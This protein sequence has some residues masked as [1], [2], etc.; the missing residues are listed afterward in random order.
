M[1]Q[2]ATKDHELWMQ[3][4]IGADGVVH[5][6]TI[7]CFTRDQNINVNGFSLSGFLQRDISFTRT[8]HAKSEVK[9]PPTAHNRV[10]HVVSGPLT[11]L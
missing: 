2:L 5:S 8:I 11:S 10:T 9:L 1:W 7:P 3:A 6:G 4:L